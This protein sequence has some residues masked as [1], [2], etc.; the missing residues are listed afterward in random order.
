M[1]GHRIGKWV[2]SAAL[3]M[4]GATAAAQDLKRLSAVADQLAKDKHFSGTL[5]V[6]KGDRILVD[7]A[8]GEANIEWHIHNQ[9]DTRFRLG[10]ITKQFTAA[11]VLLLKDRGQLQLTDT[12]GQHLPE[13]PEAWHKV[14]VYQLLTHTS[15]I[16]S[17]TDIPQ[18]AA[19]ERYTKTPA[20]ILE[21][22]RT[23]PLDFEPGSRF[24]YSNSGYVVLG[25]LIEKL[26]G[27][28]Y[29]QFL[30]KNIFDP[31][32]MKDSGYDSNLTIIPKRASGYSDHNGSLQ[33]AGFIDMSIPHAAGAL[34]STTGDLLRWQRALYG[35]KLLKPESLKA[36]TTPNLERY[37]LGLGV[38]DGAEGKQYGHGG[39]IE[40]FRTLI[41]YRPAEGI[42][43][44]M[45]SNVETPFLNE[46]ERPLFLVARG[47][48]V[49]LPSERKEIA[50]TPAQQQEVVGTYVLPDGTRFWV[51]AEGKGLSTRLG[52][53]PWVPIFAEAK[54]HFYA[55][56]VDVQYEVMRGAGN[57]VD[58]LT[59]RQNGNQLRLQRIVEKDP[60][61]ATVPFFLRG[62]MNDWGTASRMQ[63]VDG[64][65]YAATL[66]LDKSRYT[67]KLGSEDF[68]Q[69]D[70]GGVVGK[71]AMR[72]GAAQKLEAVGENLQVDIPAA[73]AYQFALD[74]TD[75][76]APQ[77]TITRAQ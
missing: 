55:R 19:N 2:L 54:D 32:G 65:T 9:P 26:S 7:R 46:I 21:A 18:Y 71:E 49:L 27:E 66:K 60:E 51:K 8:Y 22:V 10:S 31:L 12:L 39:G 29:A 38:Q 76:R 20:E 45:L 36:M 57:A 74:T 47:K 64:H 17:F 50:V 13:L 25:M 61:Y 59:L 11:S 72:L 73:G 69:I 58:A 23:M 30:Q 77:L 41:G 33:N 6:A 1:H 62:D 15:G 3:A 63:P 28:S 37:A 67:F 75:P 68:K 52:A 70:F 56:I 16:H 40:G 48:P 34:Y 4:A 24:N 5:L 35:G 14:T 43:V 42:S 44:I 53:Q